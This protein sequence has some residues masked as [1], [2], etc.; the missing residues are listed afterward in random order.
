[1][2]GLLEEASRVLEGN[3]K[4]EVASI[5]A[6]RKPIPGGGEPV[7]GQLEQIP[8]YFVAFSHSGATQGLFVPELLA[9]EIVD[10][11]ESPLLANFRPGRYS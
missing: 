6:G 9:R 4:L 5:G 10:G 3:P 1:V 11:I 7:F 2:Q 8:G